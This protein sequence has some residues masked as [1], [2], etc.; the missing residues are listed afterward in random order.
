[1][2][3]RTGVLRIATVIRGAGWAAL[4]VCTLVGIGASVMDAWTY[5]PTQDVRMSDGVIV[6]AAPKDIT[7]EKLAEHYKR[8]QRDQAEEAEGAL[9]LAKKYGG[10]VEKWSQAPL[11]NVLYTDLPD[12]T[13][14]ASFQAERFH[15]GFP[16]VFVLI[17]A[18]LCGLAYV[19]AWVV[20]GFAPEA[21]KIAQS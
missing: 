1:M 21:E 7:Q 10:T 19:V 16:A 12:S 9:K 5:P 4:V 8:F 13:L 6:L 17:G 15:W 11:V 3:F 18:I 2:S 14:K 20:S